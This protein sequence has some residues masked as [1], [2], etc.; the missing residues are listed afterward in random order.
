M[1]LFLVGLINLKP[2]CFV[3]VANRCYLHRTTDSLG[4]R[5]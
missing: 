2:S 4:S 1:L 3:I 5:D